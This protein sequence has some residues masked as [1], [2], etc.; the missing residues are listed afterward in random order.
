MPIKAI[1]KGIRWI[2]PNILINFTTHL[3]LYSHELL[4]RCVKRAVP[5]MIFFSPMTVWFY[6]LFCRLLVYIGWEWYGFLYISLICYCFWL[7]VLLFHNIWLF[8]SLLIICVSV[9]EVFLSGKI[10]EFY[11]LVLGFVWRIIFTLFIYDAFVS[12]LYQ[13]FTWMDFIDILHL[14]T[15][16]ILIFLK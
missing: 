12:N 9:V 14:V 6:F 16:L 5:I 4:T 11:C 1:K 10:D 3:I 13:I 2:Q 15:V 7:H 8:L